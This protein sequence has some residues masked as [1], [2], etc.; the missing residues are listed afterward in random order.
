MRVPDP[1]ITRMD[2]VNPEQEVLLAGA[3]GLALSVVLDTLAPAERP[4]F[5]LDDMFDLPFVE[6]APWWSAH[7]SRRGS[8][9][10]AAPGTRCR[11]GPGH[12]SHR[13]AR[14]CRRLLRRGQW[15]RLR[16]PRRRARSSRRAALRRRCSPCGRL[17]GRSRFGSRRRPGAHVRPAVG[18]PAAG[19]RER[20]CGSRRHRPRPTLSVIG[21]IVTDGKIV[22]NR[23]DRRPRA[24]GPARPD[25]RRR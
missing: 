6:I 10:G 12:Q 25:R 13:S 8:Q 3:V 2:R 19:A 21:F 16:R 14:G 7:R 17:G 9:S 22:E 5:V 4:A 18:S 15:R 24:P 1:I 20:S 23:R 11:P